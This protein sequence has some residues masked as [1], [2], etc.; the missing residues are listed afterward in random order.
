[1]ALST[2]NASELTQ[3]QVQKIL[4]RPLEAA[5]VFIAS[6]VRVFDVT[7][8][9]PVRIPKLTSMMRRPGTAKTN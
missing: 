4:V 3:E 9:G 2:V 8:A 6:G 1:M 5:S 7:A